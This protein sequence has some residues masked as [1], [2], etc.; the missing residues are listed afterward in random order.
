MLIKPTY[1]ELEQRIEE[2]EKEVLKRNQVEKQIESLSKFPSENPNPVLRITSNGIVL[3]ANN[4]AKP[5]L[6]L[7]KCK[8]GT[9]LPDYWRKLSIDVS[10]SKL[11]KYTVVEC[12]GRV[13]SLTF[14]PIQDTD[15]INVYGLDITEHKKAENTLREYALNLG[16]AQSIA[17]MG[18]WKLNLLNNHLEW[19][20]TV[21]EIFEIDPNKFEISYETFLDVVHPDDREYVNKAYAESVRKKSRYE[22]E[23]RLLMKDG[24]IK[25]LYEICRTDY[26]ISGQAIRS[27]GIVQDVTERKQIENAQIFLLQC[28]LPATGEDFFESLACYL[29][30]TL[31]MDYVFISRLSEDGL[32]ANTLAVYSNGNY[33]D[34]ISY[35]LKG[36]PCNDVVGKAICCFPKNVSSLFPDDIILQEI[37]AESYVGATLWSSKGKAI[38]LISVIGHRS[39]TDTKLAESLLKL[40]AIR[41]SAELERRQA[42]K[43]LKESEEKYRLLFENITQGFALHEIIF[44][45]LGKPSDYRFI[46]VNPAFTKLTG[47]NSESIIGKNIKEVMPNIEQYWLDI[48]EQVAVTREPVLYENYSAQLKKYFDTWV[49]SPQKGQFAIMFSD[50]TE[51]KL[52]SKALQKS[53]SELESRVM[54]R[55]NE[56][57]I[58]NKRLEH[59]IEEHRKADKSLRSA[60]SEINKLTEQLEAENIY[61]RHEINIKYQYSDIIGESESIKRVLYQ[62]EQVAPTSMTVLV[63]GETG[64]GKELISN[65]VHNMSPRKDRPIIVVNCAALPSN[66]IESELFG[67]EKG[68]YT[69]ADKRQIGRFEIANGSTLC[70]D[71]IGELP[72]D[73]QAKLLRA[74]Q[75]GQFERLGASNTIKADVRIVATTNRNLEQEVRKGRFRQDLFYR[76]NVF[77]IIVPPLRERKDDIPLLVI[78]FV[79]KYAK[80]YGK[81]ISSVSRETINRLQDYTWPGNIRELES[82]IERSVILC[83]GHILQVADKPETAPLFSTT[84]IQTLEEV[85]R[86]QILNILSHTGWRINGKDGAASILGLHP[87]TLRA[88]MNKLDI[89]RPEN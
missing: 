26:D 88:R 6:D 52:M 33:D 57:L 20:D 87:S 32:S 41:A 58:A 5:L 40:V 84:N 86:M 21:F 72:L 14:A 68:A 30:E 25:W 54:E 1:I 45:E 28:G 70:L 7:W 18:R 39:L 65:A 61:L 17:R 80:K 55:T 81:Q 19:S 63:L 85:E 3:Y 53:H 64:T 47:I 29:A 12:E 50:I 46:S 56:L 9:S 34:N 38:G 22:V 82:V 16:E 24:R 73:M 37:K 43:A 23:H 71:E 44:D 49:I 13:F 66:L 69:G 59:E 62:V 83:Q 31:T 78:A 89:Q 35:S 76:L 74:I 77:P 75:H 10:G 51:R 15:Y 36:T 67:R 4:S 48:Y 8:P 60:L 42:D 11:I 2:L 79:E 27:V